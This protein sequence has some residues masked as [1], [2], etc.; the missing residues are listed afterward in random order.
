MILHIDMD[1]FFASVEQLDNP[2]LIGKCVIVGGMSNRS[3]VSAAS[4]EARKFGVHSAMPMYKARQMCPDAVFLPP[5]MKRYKEL[6]RQIMAILKNLSPLVEPISIDEAYV[7]L[8]GCERLHGDPLT[9]S[10]KLKQE[11]R[12]K[13]HLN[14]SVGVAPNKFMAKIASDMNKPDGLKIIMPEEAPEF[15]KS[16]PVSN[17]PGVGTKMKNQLHH[18]GIIILNDVANY[19]EGLLIKKLGK[20][21]KRLIELSACIDRSCVV[22]E[23][24][25]RSVSC[26]ETLAYDTKDR[27][28]L[29][30]YVL[31]FSEAV[32]K[33]LR[34][35]GMKAKTIH[36][37]IKH[38]DFQQVTRGVT[39]E[40][41]TQA[42]EIIFSEAIQ[43]L[44]N[45]PLEKEVRLIGVGAS[46]LVPMGTYTQMDLFNE[47]KK[48][49]DNWERLDRVM[50]KIE[51]KY[52]NNIVRRASLS[53]Q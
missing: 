48:R 21:G 40:K 8:T 41:Q 14:C 36:L 51:K 25:R 38:A 53:K 3:V 43:L 32:G 6:S 13:V 16:L 9:I 39:I 29:R 7:D 33:E 50:D 37:K 46:G 44:N 34:M 28:L 27:N 23:S 1:A 19:P 26:E 30:K 10:N 17:V 20:F 49:D 52:G 35:L 4:Y 18:L 2:E 24:C 22:A 47:L 45:Y 11:I 12:T 5:R 31:R 42:S 15:I